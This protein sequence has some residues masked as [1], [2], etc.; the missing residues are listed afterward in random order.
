MKEKITIVGVVRSGQGRGGEVGAKT[1]NLDISL[2]RN[3]TKGLYACR[4]TVDKTSRVLYDGLLYYGINSLTNQDCLEVHL[5]KFKGELM[6]KEIAVVVGRYLREPKKFDT[7]EALR[8]QIS[9][10]VQLK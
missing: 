6:G 7:I 3:L 8:E 10:D 2:A 5:L 9:R 4:V 1:A